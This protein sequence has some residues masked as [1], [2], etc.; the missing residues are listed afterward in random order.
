MKLAHPGRRHREGMGY[1]IV[2][3]E[4]SK[5]IEGVALDPGHSGVGL[6]CRWHGRLVGFIMQALPATTT[7]LGAAEVEVLIRER[8][9][10]DLVR[11]R[12]EDALAEQ[13][14]SAPPPPP[15]SLTIARSKTA[16]TCPAASTILSMANWYSW[17]M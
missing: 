13:S 9:A 6:I 12:V 4:L 1:R 3:V 14:P 2:E 7:E 16:T 11:I 17:S 8:V 15:V 5:A 10:F